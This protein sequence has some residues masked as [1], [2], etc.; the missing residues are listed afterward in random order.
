[1]A[2]KSEKQFTC[3]IERTEWTTA[4]FGKKKST[5]RLVPTVYYTHTH[6]DR[7][8]VISQCRRTKLMTCVCLSTGQHTVAESAKGKRYPKRCIGRDIR[9]RVSVA[10]S[11]DCSDSPLNGRLHPSVS[12]IS[13]PN[14]AHAA[15]SR[16]A[17]SQSTR[18]CC[19]LE[20]TSKC[21]GW[22]TIHTEDFRM[23][24]PLAVDY[25]APAEKCSLEKQN[26]SS[27]WK[28]LL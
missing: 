24:T 22:L 28:K 10:L 14:G 17:R 27:L 11:A 23:G 18:R 12:W 4:S 21:L 1:M 6:T 7:F 15:H 5:H 19:T 16:T 26:F 9:G 20:C 2:S 8:P 25:N 13:S 3:E